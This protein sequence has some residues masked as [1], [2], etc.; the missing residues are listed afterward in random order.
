M[1]FI[2]TL[3]VSVP[4]LAVLDFLWLGVVAKQYYASRLSTILKPI[5][6]VPAVFQY[7][8]FGFGLTFFAT[9]PAVVAGTLWHA[10]ALGALFG[11][12]TYAAYNLTNLSIIRSW[13]G[14]IAAVDMLWGTILSTA[15]SAVAY[16]VV[17]SF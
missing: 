7:I 8:V 16:L 4:L 2:Y 14:S 5:S 11:F 12:C 3:L 9:G 17:S 10:V 15:V 6:W 13:P 1:Q